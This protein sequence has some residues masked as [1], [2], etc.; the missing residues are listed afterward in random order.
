M[1]ICLDGTILDVKRSKTYKVE[2]VFGSKYLIK[3][4]ENKRFKG[5][6]VVKKEGNFGEVT[7]EDLF[8]ILGGDLA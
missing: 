2:S 4:N 3:K 1:V 5:D 8:K 7:F 6:I